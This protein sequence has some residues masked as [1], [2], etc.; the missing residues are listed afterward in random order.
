[1]GDVYK[2][3]NKLDSALF[4]YDKHFALKDSLFNETVAGSIQDLFVNLE[5]KQAQAEINAK[6]KQLDTQRTVVILMSLVIILTIVVGWFI[7]RDLIKRRKLNVY[8]D[9]QVNIKTK[10]LLQSNAELKAKKNDLDNLIYKISHDIRAPLSRLQG[11]IQLGRIDHGAGFYDKM[12]EQAMD[13]EKILNRMAVVNS[14]THHEL[15]IADIP[16]RDF[17]NEIIKKYSRQW[18]NDVEFDISIGEEVV[19]TDPELLEISLYNILDNAVRFRVRDKAIVKIGYANKAIFV[20]D[21][22]QGFDKKYINKI[23]DLFF[24][25]NES[26]GTGIGLHHTSLA[27]QKLGAHLK[28]V[29]NASP[30]RFEI[31]FA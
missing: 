13:L 5:R 2:S 31:E 27:I 19:Q 14:I 21:N 10:Q 30:T 17:V 20:E 28:V 25:A 15:E 8:L 29:S 9:E 18:D 11:L 6:E 16:L 24:V 4:F 23:T 26:S 22:G 3:L 7:I 1:M 12:E